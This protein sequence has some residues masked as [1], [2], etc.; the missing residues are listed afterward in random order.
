M[1]TAVLFTCAGRRVDIVSAFSRAGAT[2]IAVDTSAL[3]PTL[4]HA[5]HFR[6]V[7]RIDD[8][9]YVPAL[10]AA[11]RMRVRV[12]G[13]SLAYYY[14]LVTAATTLGLVRYLRSG[15]PLMWE[16]AEGTR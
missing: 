9:G 12:P 1:S 7:P 14:V 10:A 5:D 16:Q 2:T 13:A 3:A 15:T 11:G 6:L 4:Y 8:R